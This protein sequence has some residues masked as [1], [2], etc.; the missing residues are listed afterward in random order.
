MLGVREEGARKNCAHRKIGK[1]ANKVQCTT[2]MDAT[3]LCSKISSCPMKESCSQLQHKFTIQQELINHFNDL[4]ALSLWPSS[5]IHV[6][7]Y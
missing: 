2:G 1:V 3:T 4:H 6:F 5:S 7:F